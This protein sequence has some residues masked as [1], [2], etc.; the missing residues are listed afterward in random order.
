MI[1]TVQVKLGRKRSAMGAEKGGHRYYAYHIDVEVVL[2]ALYWKQ[3]ALDGV[4]VPAA[5]AREA[6]G[7]EGRRV[8]PREVEHTAETCCVAYVTS[9]PSVVSSEMEGFAICR[10]TVMPY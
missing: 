1:L 3:T 8:L 2:A 4:V 7:A 6:G 10:R 5:A 9:S